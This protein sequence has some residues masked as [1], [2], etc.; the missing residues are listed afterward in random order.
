MSKIS[1]AIAAIV[2]DRK[3]LGLLKQKDL[4]AKMGVTPSYVSEM[5]RGERRISDELVDLFCDALGVKLADLENWNLELAKIRLS[6]VNSAEKAPPELAK[7]HTKLDRLYKVN[8]QAFDNVAGNID[9]W[10]KAV[11]PE[12]PEAEGIKKAG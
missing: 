1:K 6:S 3:E 8:R 10:L 12:T 9:Y 4:A 11:K 5:L 2:A 7:A